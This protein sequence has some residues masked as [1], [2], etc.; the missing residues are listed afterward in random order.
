MST[1]YIYNW[2]RQRLN[3]EKYLHSVGAEHAAR[4]L[5]QMFGS[6]PE[7]AACA[8][9]IHDNA[10]DI[11]YEKA[12]ELVKENDFNIEDEIKSNKKIIHAYL[13][14]FIAQKE[15]GINDEEI[16]NAVKYHTTGRAGM[17]LLEKIVFLADKIEANTREQ[18]FRDHV[19]SILKNTKNIDK[20]VLFCVDRT[21]RSLLDRKLLI[22][23]RT[24]DVW[25][26]LIPKLPPII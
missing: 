2:L 6:D 23:T 24:I 7:Q 9:L 3:P 19:W 20:A 18:A 22:N 14:A 16:L 1:D 17:S 13:G 8:A 10:K 4:E 15:L 12:L 5:A 26:S 21:I 11:Q 25:N